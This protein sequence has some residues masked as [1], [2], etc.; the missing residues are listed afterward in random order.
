MDLLSS[1]SGVP[2]FLEWVQTR[3]MDVEVTKV[4]QMMADLFRR[5]KKRHDQPVREFN[6]EFERMV[7]RLREV[8][9][10]LPPLVKAW[11]Y[12]DKLRLSEQ[13]EVS[14]LASVGN[15]YDCKRL[16]QAALIQDRSLRH[17]FGGGSAAPASGWRGGSKHAVHMTQDAASSESELEEEPGS[18][19]VDGELMDEATAAEHH[20]AYMAYQ[21]AKARYKEAL[22]GR[23][24][25]M[26]EVKKRSE[27]RLRLAKA[28]SYCSAC[29][30]RGHWHKDPECPLRQHPSGG[31]SKEVNVTTNHVQM[32]SSF[33]CCYAA[34]TP[35]ASSS[36][37]E[38]LAILDTACTK[39]VAGYPW[40]ERFYAMADALDLPFLV[41]EELDSFQFGASKIYQSTFAIWGWFA[42]EGKWVAVKVSIVPCRVPLLFS[43]PVLSALGMQYDL[44][45]QKVSLPSLGVFDIKTRVSD[46]GHPA[47]WV[48]Q[49]PEE[50]P[51]MWRGEPD[52]V[53]WIPTAAE[54]YMVR[55]EVVGS[56]SSKGSN[57]F[58]PKKVP[59][60]VLNMLQSEVSVG[61]ASFYSW[62][63]SAGQTRDFWVETDIEMIR[64]HVVPRKH[65]FDPSRWETHDIDTKS[66]LLRNI[67]GQRLTEAIPCLPE[68]TLLQTHHGHMHEVDPGRRYGQ[69]IGRSRFPKLRSSH[70]SVPAGASADE[71]NGIPM[72]DEEVGAHGRVGRQ[73]GAGPHVVDGA[74]AEGVGD[75][76]SP[77]LS[78]WG[79][80][81]RQAEGDHQ[82]DDQRVGRGGEGPGHYGA[83]ASQ[84]GLAHQGDP[85]VQQ[86]PGGH[87]RAVREVQGLALPGGAP[88]VFAVVHQGGGEQ[89][90]PP[91]GLGA[92]GRMGQ[93]KGGEDQGEAPAGGSRGDGRD[94]SAHHQ[95]AGRRRE[96]QFDLESGVFS[97]GCQEQLGSSPKERAFGDSGGRKG[98]DAFAAGPHGGLAGSDAGQHGRLKAPEIADDEVLEDDEGN[99]HVEYE[100]YFTSGSEG[101]LSPREKAVAGLRRR[102]RERE[103]VWQRAKRNLHSI[104]AVCTAC[105][106]ALGGFAKE[107]LAE[108]VAEVF[109]VF[110]PSRDIMNGPREVDCLELFA[111]QGRIS[112]A[113]ARRGRGVLQP[114]D[115]RF[116]H[117]FKDRAVREEI[118]A[119]I[120]EY[121]PGLV[122][123]APP[124]TAWCAFS[125]LNFS[126][127]ELRRRRRRDAALIDFVHEVF[128]VQREGGRQAVVE[129]PW[130]SDLWRHHVLQRWINADGALMTHVDLCSYGMT[131]VHGTG[132]L[133]KP[134]GLLSFS[135]AFAESIEARCDG[136][137]QHVVI[138]GKQTY[139]S[140]VYPSRFARAVVKAYDAG[141]ARRVW[142]TSDLAASSSAP[143]EDKELGA[144]AISF[145]G[146]VNPAIAATLRR[147]HQNLGHPPTRELVRHLRIG[148][149]PAAV[150]NAAEQLVCRTCQRC[151]RAKSH[152]VS[153]PVMAL[154]FNEA[155]A[156]DVLWLDAADQ[157]NL[158][159]LN[160]VDLASTYQVVV[161]LNDTTSSEIARAFSVGWM[162]WAGTPKYVLTDLD[163]GFKDQFLELMDQR[164]V[165]VRCAAGQAH[166]QNGV[167][168]RHGATWKEI[169][170]KL[171]EENLILKDEL[172]E[173][174]AAVSDAKNS[175]RNKSG[176]SPRQ[177]VFG[178][179][180][181]Q[182][183]D[184]FDGDHELPGI[185]LES[186]DAKFSRNQ[187]IR[188]GA[189]AAFF[190]CQTK[191]ALQRAVNHQA[192]VQPRALDIGDLAYIYREG[193]QARSKKPAARWVGPAVVIG[194]EGSNYWL[195]RGGRC[196]LAAPEHLRVAHHEEVSE[197]LRI[198]MAMK[199]VQD[200]MTS[201]DGELHE[202]VDDSLARDGQPVR[203]IGAVEMEA[204]GSEG[205]NLPGM[206]AEAAS[207]EQQIRTATRRAGLLDDVPVSL[208]KPRTDEGPL[209]H[210]QFMVKRCISE[211]GREKQLEKELPWGMIP[212]DERPLYHDAEKKQWDEHVAFGAVRALTIEE[213]DVVRQTVSP[214]RIL[215]ARFAYK[216]KNYSKRKCDPSVP[217]KPKARLCVGGHNDPD[218]GRMDM[219][220]DAP[221]TSRHSILLAIQLSL[222]RE[223]D[224]SVGDVKAAFLNG[225]PAPRQ[226]YFRQPRNGIPGLDS[227]QLVEI[228]KGV[229]GLSTSPKLWW[230]K[231][232]SDIKGMVLDYDGEKVGVV[233]NPI[234]PC[235]FMLQGK[236]SKKVRGLMLTHV[237]DIMLLAEPALC[238][239]VQKGLGELFP[240]E[241]WESGS[242]EYVGCEYCCTK[243]EV[244]ITQKHYT[245]G[246]I[247][248]IS[249]KSS[250]V[251]VSAEQMEENRTVIGSLSWLSKQT[252]PDLRFGVS[253]AQKTQNDPSVADLIKVNK[254]VDT[255][256]AH[257]E[258]GI[259]L[260][261]IPEEQLAVVAFHDAA[262][263]NV[264]ADDPDLADP[265]WAGAH[266]LASQLASLVVIADAA[267]MQGADARFSVVEWKSKA[268]QRVCRSTFAGETMACNEGLESALFLRCLLLSFMKG[269]LLPESECG[270]FMQL[271]CVT[272]CRSLYDHIHKEG[273][274]KAPSEKRLAIDLAGLRQ[275][276]MQEARHQWVERHGGDLEP[277]PERP[278]KPPLHWVPTELQLAD[279][280]TKDLKA[281][282]WWATVSN[283]ILSL[284]LHWT[285]RGQ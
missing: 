150:V 260:R 108:P 80:G 229:F 36:N 64:V 154:D 244:R 261:K 113:F 228:I 61:S 141:E 2:Y 220:V 89:P 16:Q 262:W 136:S 110:Q 99:P 177:W 115:L 144:E 85:A 237:D 45:A 132:L 6:V 23:G 256:I 253:Q 235:V 9:C 280:L 185:P 44:Q 30:R 138:E 192:R 160:V 25:D 205:P 60:E 104:L 206:W 255:A 19:A 263:G 54:V 62:W 33:H 91:S 155:V 266:P 34:F 125:R 181:R 88:P 273:I 94:T 93:G 40:F 194:K 83:R 223:W 217:A 75:R 269:V 175:L 170:G 107:V 7:L 4:S 264:D 66:A 166:W 79:D 42:I 55:T 258:E 102:R 63:K 57:L 236:D 246:R 198:K 56:S 152:K 197:L 173:A 82:E 121:K 212:P 106:L 265:A 71:F 214:D 284:P 92:H 285:K 176:F 248:K 95:R 97:S 159:A 281:G 174:V 37:E 105:S 250:D 78:G 242:F 193:K 59:S 165:V 186:P 145:R 133:R 224:I 195:A 184:L 12:V 149:A 202:E 126:P 74:R 254:L 20:S 225:I 210:M 18:T 39:A 11:L 13:E 231:L 209:P 241:E 163:S 50:A 43:R 140:S 247:Q 130:S 182:V 249:V 153:Q 168:E 191:Q 137:H 51:P 230:M 112:E 189:R 134:V 240:V 257:R 268:S 162:Q 169:W 100:L 271:H 10:E 1:P 190:R 35:P 157:A 188:L 178:S 22:K 47:L 101:A 65:L 21:G 276:L 3:F 68:G 171:V 116:G 183:G 72:E 226:L 84:Q 109:A 73:G 219:S 103:G 53:L 272:D 278:L 259:V 267:S 131:S 29:K 146:K 243:D 156:A 203:Q 222:A 239:L 274:P 204:E 123:M 196:M 200:L 81:Q 77:G 117:D 164:C 119:E 216:D 233:Q 96:L 148:G 227:R 52:G 14:L 139:H 218:L 5:C 24:I 143:T 180:G 238:P 90:Q 211:K 167:A 114:R 118:L 213:S 158:P 275:A 41:C 199:E 8:Q 179:N 207:R 147:V 70:S 142:M 122:W 49:F 245:D 127:Q 15:E 48:S 31:A 215:T 32:C 86:R 26:E 129:N 128:T 135:K 172:S 124:C 67:T 98:G 151:S 120:R 270:R 251:S 252:R 161:P 208:K 279:I 76:S 87:D 232:S 28:R 46:T 17:G 221:T 38:M 283:G 187:V 277:T 234:D 69:W 111:G 27:E 201:L 58:Y 282:D